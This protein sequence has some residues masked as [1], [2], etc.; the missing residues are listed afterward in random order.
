MM[1]PD[2]LLEEIF[3]RL[4]PGEP[5]CLVRAYL[6]SKFWLGLLSSARFHSRYREFHG[7]PPML[8]FVYALSSYTQTKVDK[9]IPRFVSTTEFAARVPDDDLAM[10]ALTTDYIALDCHHGRVLLG[11]RK[12][13]PLVVWDPMAGCLTKMQALKGQSRTSAAAVLCAVTGC[14]HCACHHGP[15]QVFFFGMSVH[16]AHCVIHLSVFSSETLGWSEPQPC[17]GLDLDDAAFIKPAP[18]VAI[19]GALYFMQGSFED[20]HITGF[21]KYDLGSNCLSLIDAPP[22]RGSLIIGA[23]TLMAMEDDSLGFAQV[24]RLTIYLWSR[25]MGSDGVASW[26]QPRIIDL[27]NLLPIQ[28][29]SGRIKLIGS[30]EG[31]DI[32]FVT[33]DLGIYELN[34]KSL[35]WK[36]LWGKKDVWCLFPCMSFPGPQERMISCDAAH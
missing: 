21:L 35:H 27:K 31:S 26:T 9:P 32:I 24:K 16:G 29:P 2:D 20:D 12:H 13:N 3:L 30:L 22:M 8:G 5:A 15:F 25:H 28:N 6:A 18:S 36:K 1:L 10:A 34:L 19:Q 17:L 14:D 7:A 23:N 11:D 33:T 4:P